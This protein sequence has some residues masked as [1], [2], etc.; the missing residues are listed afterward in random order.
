MNQD[1]KQDHRV[2]ASGNPAGGIT[3]G[4][5]ISISWQS[6]PLGRGDDRKQPNGAFVEGVIAAAI[7]RLEFYQTSKFACEENANALL[8]LQGALTVLQKRTRDR[9]G[10]G[11][12][13]THSK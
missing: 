2:D 4:T 1:L 9:E 6:G 8:A 10:R 12:E 3:I 7:G 13:G 5:G 11:V